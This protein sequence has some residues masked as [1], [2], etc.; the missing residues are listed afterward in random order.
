[1]IVDTLVNEFK[2][3]ALSLGAGGNNCRPDAFAPLPPTF[4]ACALRDVAIHDDKADRLV[5]E[6]IGGVEGQC[7][8]KAKV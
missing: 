1:M 2:D 8:D 4:A 3:T 5:R 7:G 6:M